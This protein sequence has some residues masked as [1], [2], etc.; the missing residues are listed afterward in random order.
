[1]DLDRSEVAADRVATVAVIDLATAA[2]PSTSRAI[3][4]VRN[5]PQYWTISCGIWTSRAWTLPIAILLCALF[6]LKAQ[7]SK[8]LFL[9][10]ASTIEFNLDQFPRDISMLAYY[11]EFS[12]TDN[13]IRLPKGHFEGR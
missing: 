10:P 7:L 8:D 2:T 13:S 3:P 11:V 4:N 5:H 9:L 12:S 6:D 1:V